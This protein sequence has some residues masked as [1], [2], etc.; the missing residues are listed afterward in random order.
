M[1]RAVGVAPAW[2][3][4]GACIAGLDT[5]D[6]PTDQRTFQCSY[7]PPYAWRKEPIM[8]K[9]EGVHGSAPKPSRR[10]D[11]TAGVTAVNGPQCKPEQPTDRS[12][13][14]LEELG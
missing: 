12:G 8:L 4:H 5:R 13:F 9:N 3:L 10:L 11:Q 2:R 1:E 7:S 14:L 6:G